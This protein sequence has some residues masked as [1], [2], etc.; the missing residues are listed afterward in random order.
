MKRVQIQALFGILLFTIAACLACPVRAQGRL[1]ATGGLTQIEGAAGGGLVPWALIAGYGT[2]DETGGTAF[3]TYIDTGNFRLSAAG[4]A[5]GIRDRVE[6]SFAEQRLDLGSTVPGKSLALDV[7]GLKVKV[8]GDAV[9]DQDR[10]MPQIAAGIQYKQNRDFDTVPKALGAKRG[11]D[12]D[13]YVAATKVILAGLAGR[14]VVLNGVVRETRANQLG[15]L[16]F[17]GDK[18]DSYRPEFEGTAGIFLTDKLV[19]GVEYRSKPDNL[20]VFREQDFA[21]AFVA[22]VPNK[23]IAFTAAYANLGNIANKSNQ[24]ALY[25]SMQLS[26]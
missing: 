26:F 23:H 4:G 3:G 19:V 6:V 17:G 14:N 15:L 22:Y 8:A 9:Y 1:L 2:R 16:G 18:N 25:L 11:S 12:A 10:W 7:I 13:F 24:N 21:D 20:S 5:I